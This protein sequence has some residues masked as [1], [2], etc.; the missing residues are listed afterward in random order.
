MIAYAGINTPSRFKFLFLKLILPLVLA[1]ND[2]PSN[3]VFSIS[4]LE[5]LI[6]NEPW[7]LEK[8]IPSLAR[9]SNK[10]VNEANWSSLARNDASLT[11]KFS[12]RYFPDTMS[13]VWLSNSNKISPLPAIN[14]SDALIFF[15]NKPKS[16]KVNFSVLLLVSSGK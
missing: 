14:L 1:P 5:F 16:K 9:I 3:L 4:I 7:R 11:L 2:R 13:F 15:K 12:T 6:L 8:G 10:P